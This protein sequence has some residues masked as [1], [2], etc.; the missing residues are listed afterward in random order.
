MTQPTMT[1]CNA[2]AP[3]LQKK[4]YAGKGNFQLS[5]QAFRRM[6]LAMTGF[7]LILGLLLLA[8]FAPV[9]TTYSPTGM[10]AEDRLQG[11]TLK[12]LGGTDELGRDILTRT[13]F[14]I[15]LA[16]KTGLISV[17]LA[18]L[19][20]VPAGLISGFSKGIADSLIMRLMDGLSAFPPLILAIAV[21]AALGYGAN[22]A[23][24]AIAI[25][26][27]PTFARITRGE[28]LCEQEEVYVEAAVSIGAT[29]TRIIMRH[30]LPNI[31]SP[32]IVQ[33]SLLVSHAILAEASLSFLGI[34][35]QPPAPSWGTMLKT[36]VGYLSRNIW[37]AIM[38]GTA[39][40]LTVLGTNFVGDGLRDAMDPMIVKK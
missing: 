21:T 35:A 8:A 26:Y 40:F 4:E 25:T 18:V 37:M 5:V 29:N 14:G 16:L 24:I 9:L 39:L 32:L 6:P 7:Y 34:G 20:G 12:H 10:S 23:L 11:P 19:I 2:D 3:Q 30:I 36:S 13:I 17:G 31:I 1:Q 33:A 38:P 27:I 22:N 28:V 15:R